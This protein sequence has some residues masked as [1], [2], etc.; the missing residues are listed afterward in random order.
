M[1]IVESG[2]N[3]KAVSKKN[4]LG[5]F[6]LLPGTAAQYGVNH[7]DLFNAE[8]NIRVGLYHFKTLLKQFNNLDL[9]LAAYNCGAGRVVKSGY[10]I[11]NITETIN[12]VKKVKYEA[13][14]YRKKRL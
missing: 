9:A 11:P 7:E 10:L 2:L 4:A 1:A 12:Y 6:Q 14:K 3:I 8:I 13:R 5:L